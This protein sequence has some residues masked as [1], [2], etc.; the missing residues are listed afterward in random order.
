MPSVN[1]YTFY[2]LTDRTGSQGQYLGRRWLPS[3]QDA[4]DLAEAWCDELGST[5]EVAKGEELDHL[6]TFDPD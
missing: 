6:A 1:V 4:L 2:A 3:D 5:V